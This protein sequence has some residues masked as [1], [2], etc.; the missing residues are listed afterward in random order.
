MNQQIKPGYKTTEFWLS[1]LTVILGTAAPSFDGMPML[2]RII[3][4][5]LSVLATLGYTYA[6]TSIKNQ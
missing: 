3:G 2:G 5:A 6:R 4:L 1:L